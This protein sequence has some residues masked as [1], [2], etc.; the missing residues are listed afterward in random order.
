M[1]RLLTVGGFSVGGVGAVSRNWVNVT[2]EYGTAEMPLTQTLHIQT[3]HT[4]VQLTFTSQWT[5]YNRLLFP[6]AGFVFS[7]F[8]GTSVAEGAADTHFRWWLTQL[9][10]C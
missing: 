4:E 10:P 6:A 8:E 5:D 7:D 2:D 3:T 9:A 1:R